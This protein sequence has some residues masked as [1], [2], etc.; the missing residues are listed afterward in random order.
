[1]KPSSSDINSGKIRPHIKD[2]PSR[3][4]EPALSASIM[5]IV[6]IEC[7]SPQLLV[8][9]SMEIDMA[10]LR[11]ISKEESHNLTDLLSQI[12]TYKPEDRTSLSNIA[13]HPW[14]TASVEST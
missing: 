2:D 3:P 8:Q 11:K 14:L 7:S 1:M 4:W 9:A 12:L 5:D 10:P 6:L 13:K